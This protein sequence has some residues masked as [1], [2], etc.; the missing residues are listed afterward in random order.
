MLN[1]DIQ[2]WV[3]N[4]Q[5]LNKYW[6]LEVSVMLFRVFLA[7]RMCLWMFTFSLFRILYFIIISCLLTLLWI[8]VLDIIYGILSNINISIRKIMD[9]IVYNWELDWPSRQ[10]VSLHDISSISW[11][12]CFT[13]CNQKQS[14]VTTMCGVDQKLKNGHTLCSYKF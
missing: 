8:M 6:Y 9:T 7:Y 11:L 1:L 13:F 10:Q 12:G 5:E 2:N 4:V 3:S 14:N